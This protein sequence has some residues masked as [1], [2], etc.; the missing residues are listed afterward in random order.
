[1]SKLF[2]PIIVNEELEES[3][4]NLFSV[5]SHKREITNYHDSEFN[6]YSYPYLDKILKCIFPANTFSFDILEYDK[7]PEFG[8][9]ENF[10]ENTASISLGVFCSAYA[11]I[12]NRTYK[13][14]YDSITLTGN[15]QIDNGKIKLSDVI[16]IKEKFEAATNYAKNHANKKHLFIYVSTNNEIEEGETD[17]LLVIRFSPTDSINLVFAEIFEP[18]YSDLQKQSVIP[19]DSDIN[20][21]ETKEFLIEKKKLARLDDWH[22]LLLHGEQNS[23]KTLVAKELCKYLMTVNNCTCDVCSIDENL[24]EKILENRKL[25]NNKELYDYLADKIQRGKNNSQNAD[26][27]L[28]DNVQTAHINEFV[29]SL[30]GYKNNYAKIVITTWYPIQKNANGIIC[31]SVSDFNTFTLRQFTSYVRNNISLKVLKTNKEEIIDLVEVLYEKYKNLPG[32]IPAIVRNLPN[33]GLKKI[34][35]EINADNLTE[36]KDKSD[37]ALK[38]AFDYMDFFSQLVIFAILGNRLV[39]KK[40]KTHSIIEAISKAV[41]KEENLLSEYMISNSISNLCSLNIIQIRKTKNKSE[42]IEM[43]DSD[44]DWLVFNHSIN[45]NTEKIR[46]LLVPSSISFIYAAKFNNMSY[47]EEYIK[48]VQ[49]SD[50]INNAL[51]YLCKYHYED[52]LIKGICEKG[53]DPESIIENSLTTFNIANKRNDE[54]LMSL[55]LKYANK[56]NDDTYSNE[57]KKSSYFSEILGNGKQKSFL[58]AKY[59]VTQKLYKEIMGYN[60]SEEFIGD[61]KPVNKVSYKDAIDFCNKLSSKHCLKSVYKINGDEITIDK[62]ADGYRLPTSKEWLYSAKDLRNLEDINNFAWYKKNTKQI[63]EVGLKECNCYGLFDLLGNV[64]EICWN[65]DR[66]CIEDYGGNYKNKADFILQFKN[67]AHPTKNSRV[68]FRIA[69][70]ANI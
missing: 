30:K 43:K 44:L 15:L 22:I 3:R 12:N 66:N 18:N 68:G 54:K 10:S 7:N 65:V 24:E 53:A 8:V 16:F 45:Q 69:K 23:G 20:F 55:L 67:C 13:S 56:N 11:E 2:V 46:A 57:V 27:L 39:G 61:D 50:D 4:C 47:I 25:E 60:P 14:T 5:I 42:F 29:K 48:T 62:T 64:C 49:N 21:I 34:I 33:N 40:I 36:Y 28:I 17:N 38:R 70:N 35:D 52:N 6:G 51:F 32:Y 41:L 59:Q 37:F 19:L 1:M 63:M 58:M 31:Q 9:F 26:I